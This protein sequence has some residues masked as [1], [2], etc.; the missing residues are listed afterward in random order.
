MMSFSHST[1]YAIQALACLGSGE[2]GG[3][4]CFIKDVAE[5]SGVPGP[6]LAR[7]MSRLAHHG[8]VIAKRGYRGGIALARPPHQISALDIV[9]AMEGKQWA[10]DCMFSIHACGGDRPCPTQAF[11]NDIRRQMTEKLRSVTLADF[12][13]VA[14]ARAG[15]KAARLSAP[16][17]RRAA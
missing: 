16:A 17:T 7:V 5:C 6:Y 3:P 1:G 10:G 2:A 15:A 4:L 8:I 13:A 12:I 9:E 11:W 14:S